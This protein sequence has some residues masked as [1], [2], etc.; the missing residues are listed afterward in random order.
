MSEKT[1]LQAIAGA[2]CPR[3]RV[4]EMFQYSTYHLGGFKFMEMHKNC[5]QCD[6][7]YEV[8]PGFFYGAMYIS[9]AFS[10]AISVAG[11]VATYVLGGDPDAWVY[12][13]VVS[14]LLFLAVPFSFRYARVLMLHVFAG[15]KYRPE[16][17]ESLEKRE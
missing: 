11:S 1:K 3:C 4:G 16:L 9:Y 15:I 8:E 13:T 10:I 7:K 6:F 2:K 12:I 17:A 14:V 5:P